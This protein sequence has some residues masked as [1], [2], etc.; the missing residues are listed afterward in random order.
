MKASTI[1]TVVRKNHH[2]HGAMAV[3]FR[4]AIKQL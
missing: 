1:K 4:R 3:A 2:C